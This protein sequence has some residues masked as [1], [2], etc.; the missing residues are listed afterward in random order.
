MPHSTEQVCDSGQPIYRDIYRSVIGTSAPQWSSGQC[1]LFYDWTG[2]AEA[3]KLVK[4]LVRK[5]VSLAR[6]IARLGERTESMGTARR[7]NSSCRDANFARIPS[8]IYT[9][10]SA[11]FN[12]CLR[13]VNV[14]TT[15]DIRNNLKRNFLFWI[16]N[17]ICGNIDT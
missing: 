8:T 17:I 14:G 1:W 4:L 15:T 13:N 5:E 11:Q 2:F 16:E 7:V 6:L 12:V 3:T 9:P 10:Q